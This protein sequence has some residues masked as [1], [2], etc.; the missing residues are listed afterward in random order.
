MVAVS[1]PKGQGTPAIVLVED[2]DG[3]RGA[4]V[5]M[6]TVCGFEVL[7]FSTAEGARDDAPWDRTA[8]LLA[9]IRLPGIS[10]FDLIEWLRRSG[11]QVPS[12]AMTAAPSQQARDVAKSLGVRAFF[13]KPIPGPVLVAAIRAAIVL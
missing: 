3:L 4:L 11:R 6:L 7:P 8:C 12:I 5:G 2:D 13:E 9:D 10:G 1:T